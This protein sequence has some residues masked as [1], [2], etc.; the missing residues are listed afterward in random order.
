[1]RAYA[2]WVYG[3]QQ[4]AVDFAEDAARLLPGEEIAVRA[5]NLTTLGNALTQY[6]A[7]IRAVEAL[8]QAVVLAR[9]AGQSHVFMPAA[10]ALA[11]AYASLGKLHKAHAVCLDAVEVAEAYQRRYGLP[12]PAAASVYATLAGILA[13]WGETQQSIQ[14]A[15]KGLALSELWGQADTILLCLLHLTN[16]LSLAHDF[17]A[18]RQVIQRA[19][20][21]AQ[22]VSPWF[23][24]NVDH[25]ELRIWLDAGDIGQATRTAQEANAALPASL[26]ARL[27]LMNNRLDEALS[28]LDRALPEAIQA[29]SIETV[30]LVVFQSLAL[31]LKKDETR[32]IAALKQ[33]LYLA[34]PENRVATFVR[35]GDPMEKLLHLALVKSGGWSV[36]TS[37]E[38]ATRL[39]GAFEAWP[40]LE[41]ARSAEL[42]IESLSERE[43]EVLHY[44]NSHLSTPEIAVQLF[45][46]ASTVRTHIKNIYSKLGVHGR[47]GAVRRAKVLGLLA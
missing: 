12:L 34:E 32:A 23:V 9:Q 18:A 6:K 45:V 19:R 47:S 43:I 20:K 3:S 2:A 8:E 38:F 46:S 7:D 41:P 21:V 42:Y 17:E 33:A 36:S 39:L 22:K 40:R 26:E 14:A 25:E 11:Y 10:S 13:E 35:E 16:G 28:L 27:L 1:M 24:L 4:A 37:P 15:R 5:L 44:L 29:P 30:R 31:F